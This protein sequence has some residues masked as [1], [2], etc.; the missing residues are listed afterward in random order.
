MTEGSNQ[1]SPGAYH[2]TPF[3]APSGKKNLGVASALT[4]PTPSEKRDQ[5]LPSVKTA[6]QRL[7][8]ELDGS[9]QRGANR[10]VT[11]GRAVRRTEA[12]A[13]LR[14]TVA[15]VGTPVAGVLAPSAARAASR[16]ATPEP[17]ISERVAP[18]AATVAGVTVPTP[19][20]VEI[21]DP[22]IGTNQGAVDPAVFENL[23][24]NVK[25][26]CLAELRGNTPAEVWEV[27]VRQ[28]REQL[29]DNQL[30]EGIHEY[31]E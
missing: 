11:L 21:S 30:R 24:Q 31:L 8:R 9:R 12:G 14:A 23:H 13:P 19:S 18:R 1:N 29:N 4:P 25:L 26:C 2:L 22:V 7:L 28:L 10:A 5:Q 6:G 20:S 17:V 15:V 3:E 16:G 27:S